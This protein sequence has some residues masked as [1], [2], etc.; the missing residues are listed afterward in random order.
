MNG[1]RDPFFCV[2]RISHVTG[3]GRVEL[4][5][6]YHD[7]TAVFAFFACDR[8]SLTALL[9]AGRLVP[10]FTWRSKALAGLALFEYRATSIGTYNEVGVAIPA[11]WARGPAPACPAVDLMRSADLRRVGYHIVD[12]PV[13]TQAACAAGKD[14]WGYPKFVTRIDFSLIK[15]QLQCRVHDPG[16]TGTIMSLAGT[17][18]CG[19]PTPSLDLVTYECVDDQ[20]RRTIIRSRGAAASIGEGRLDWTWG[21][22]PTPWGHAFGAWG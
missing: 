10:A 8:D 16:S 21:R 17:L 6:L 1:Y 15:R 9:P 12:L 3:Q 7:S 18:G 2:P 19:V 13:T 22:H 5:I 20:D 11:I 4:P 14:I